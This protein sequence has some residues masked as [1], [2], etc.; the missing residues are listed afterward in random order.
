MATPDEDSLYERFIDEPPPP[1]YPDMGIIETT[2]V[3]NQVLARMQRASIPIGRA[4]VF[5]QPCLVRV[6]AE[7]GYQP[8]LNFLLPRDRNPN[9]PDPGTGQWKLFDTISSSLARA[10]DP[11][12]YTY[13]ALA[14]GGGSERTTWRSPEP[15][16]ESAGDRLAA[17]LTSSL[18]QKPTV[19]ISKGQITVRASGATRQEES[20]F[21]KEL[22]GHIKPLAKGVRGTYNPG[23]KWMDTTYSDIPWAEMYDFLHTFREIPFDRNS[24]AKVSARIAIDFDEDTGRI[25]AFRNFVFQIWFNS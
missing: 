3:V 16:R 23:A 13:R 1:E 11:Q 8:A 20:V 22:N 5:G 17:F 6:C 21:L 7:P 9:N 2:S 14:R 25:P 10:Q 19:S 15:E 18:F 12:A 24:G 4:M